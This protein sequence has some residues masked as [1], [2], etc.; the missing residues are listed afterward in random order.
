MFDSPFVYGVA[1][2]GMTFLMSLTS[3]LLRRK[4]APEEQS[5]QWQADIKKWQDDKERAK[6]T[7]DKRLQA[8][9]KRQEKR[10]LQ[11][12]GKMAKRQLLSMAINIGFLFVFWQVLTFLFFD[13]T[14]A[15]LPFWIPFVG[16]EQGSPISFIYWY[17][18]CSFLSGAI[19]QRI[20]GVS[21]GFGMQPQTTE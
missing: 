18:I 8:K 5:R 2:F 11:V 15:F 12:Q 16:L 13:K 6:K 19:I 21:M 10:I 3:S 4:I 20:L 9:L 17:F 1:V 14:V 7:G